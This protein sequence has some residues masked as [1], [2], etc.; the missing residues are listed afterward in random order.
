[1]LT[2]ND[3]ENFINN[4]NYDIRQT[5]NGRWIDQKCAADVVTIIAD[6]IYNYSMTNPTKNKFTTKDIWLSEYAKENI[7]SIF[8]K[9]DVNSAKAKNE[10]DKFFQQ[11]MELL[12][13]ANVLKKT[14]EARTNIYSILNVEILEYLALRERNTLF[15]LAKYIEK[16]LQD[17]NIYYL[18][19]N[20]FKQQNK[21]NY[22]KMKKGFA[23]FTISHTK[24]NGIAECNRIFIK[25]LNPL[26]YY[27]NSLGTKKGYISKSNITYDVLMY[28]RDN[29]RDINAEKPKNMTRKEYLA[30]QKISPNNEYFKYLSNKAKKYLHA[31]NEKYRQNKSEHFDELDHGIATQIHHIFPESIYPEISYYLENLIA[32]TPSQHMTKAH[33]NNNTREICEIYQQLLLLSKAER[34]KENI[35]KQD[36]DKIYEFGKFLY[37]LSVGFDDT[38]I[39]N[40]EDMDFASVVQIINLHY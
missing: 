15:F 28:N 40:I 38:E 34:I 20:F 19:D 18:F 21:E 33:P 35:T 7:E 5:R 29:F 17:S 22:D 11:P 26:A 10:Y 8:K 36:V 3:I 6:C 39:N 13:A 2:N 30:M 9:P 24:I 25:V 31:Y 16:T 4:N 27:K 32:L 23:D 12:A 1:M 37:V 14:K